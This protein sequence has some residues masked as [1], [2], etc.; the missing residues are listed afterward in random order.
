VT[1]KQ[2]FNDYDQN[3]LFK[4]Y[5]L[6]IINEMTANGSSLEEICESFLLVSTTKSIENFGGNNKNIS[7]SIDNLKKELF[8]YLCDDKYLEDR[9][10]LYTS[11]TN[12]ALT[13]MISGH[14]GMIFSLESI[15]VYPIVVLLIP[16][17][18]K[19]GCESYKNVN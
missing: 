3:I 11:K 1:I 17:F 13:T 19:I 18:R 5:Q 16:T 12:K 10:R 2:L 7:V 8:K 6:N 4:D 14:L 15:I 9:K